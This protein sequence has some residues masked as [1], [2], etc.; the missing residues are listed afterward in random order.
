MRVKICGITD[1]NDARAAVDAGADAVGLVFAESP[2]RVTPDRARQIVAALPPF[3]TPVGLFVD[4]PTLEIRGLAESVGLHA[5]QLH[6]SETPEE[7][8]ELAGYCVIKA[9]RVRDASFADRVQ[10][11]LSG[12]GRPAALLYDAYSP[13][14]HGGTGR[15]FDWHLLDQAARS[16]AIGSDPPPMVLAGGLT[17]GNVKAAIRRLRPYAVDTSSGVEIEP[18]RK[19]PDKIVQFVIAAKES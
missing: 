5:L 14:A 11:F 13:D 9:I 10:Q 17:P 4:C 19:D 1:V 15:K 3:V 8:A 16:G 2:R 6:G 12:P 7:V 18:G